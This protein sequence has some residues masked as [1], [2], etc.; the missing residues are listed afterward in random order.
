MTSPRPLE[1]ERRLRR[2]LSH[3]GGRVEI[4][5]GTAHE[6]AVLEA[7]L[8]VRADE[9]VLTQDIHGFHSYAARLH[10]VTARELIKGLLPR[11]PGN[12]LDPFCGSGTVL[13]EARRLGHRAFGV[14][15]NPL[16]VELSR[17]KTAGASARHAERLLEAARS[18]AARADERRLQKAGPTR[19][20]SQKDR[21]LF[22][23]HVLLELDG[24]SNAIRNIEEPAVRQSSMLVLSAMLNKVSRKQSDTQSQVDRR[25]LKS[26]FAIRVFE[27]KA[28]ELAQ[29]LQKYASELP[30]GAPPAS[31]RLGDAQNLSHLRPRTMD[32]I[33]TSPP[34]P[35][36]YDY[37]AQHALRLRWLDLPVR[38]F[39][40]GELGARRRLNRLSFDAALDRWQRELGTCLAEM[41]RVCRAPALIALVLADSVMAG[42]AVRADDVVRNVAPRERLELVAHAA[43]RRPEFHSTRSTRKHFRR[44][45]LLLLRR[46]T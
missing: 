22:E 42:Q 14:D 30:S 11:P 25:R 20:Y 26:G 46:R 31:I 1:K 37:Y 21:E 4:R 9:S 32:L 41:R 3:V 27:H 15:I 39:E 44:E 10:P 2:A 17:L 23:P 18:V 8:D 40:K 6:R 45:H 16:A 12:V 13:V 36:V 35:G 28:R 24:L 38:D 29:K 19:R 34:Y 43:Q 33:V 5:G 7:A